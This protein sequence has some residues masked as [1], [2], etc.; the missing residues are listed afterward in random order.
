VGGSVVAAAAEA[1]TPAEEALWWRQLLVTRRKKLL[2]L[3]SLFLDPS[4]PVIPL[5]FFLSPLLQRSEP[6]STPLLLFQ[7][8]NSERETED[9]RRANRA[10]SDRLEALSRSMGSSGS[11]TAA[12]SF[13]SSTMSLQSELLAMSV[14]V[15]SSLRRCAPARTTM[16]TTSAKNDLSYG[17]LTAALKKVTAPPRL[18]SLPSGTFHRTYGKEKERG[19]GRRDL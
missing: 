14:P 9:L 1:A 16:S 10:L 18:S 17:F 15:G 11:T 13:A 7:I 3:Y 4:P 8:R 5:L 6:T 19:R 2:S 12:T